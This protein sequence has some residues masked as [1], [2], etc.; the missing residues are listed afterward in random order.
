[1]FTKVNKCEKQ[2]CYDIIKLYHSNNFI[3]HEGVNLAYI[4]VSR[5]PDTV[6]KMVANVPA[7]IINVNSAKRLKPII[8][9]GFAFGNVR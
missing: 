3:M 9:V 7:N 8:G 6:D 1:M 2:T 4:I 5:I